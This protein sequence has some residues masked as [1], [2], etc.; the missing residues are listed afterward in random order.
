MPI[1]RLKGPACYLLKICSS[2]ALILVAM[3]YWAAANF[4]P[5]GLKIPVLISDF[6]QK[7]KINTEIFDPCTRCCLNSI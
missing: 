6:T 1:N 3:G 2:P 5:Q 7:S 4:T